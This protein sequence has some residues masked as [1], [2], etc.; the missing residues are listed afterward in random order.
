[1]RQPGG[2][3]EPGRYSPEGREPCTGAL[4]LP[5]VPLSGLRPRTEPLPAVSVLTHVRNTRTCLP[6]RSW[7]EFRAWLRRIATLLGQ[8]RRPILQ[9]PAWSTCNSGSS[10]LAMPKL[11]PWMCVTVIIAPGD[12][13]TLV[14]EWMPVDSRGAA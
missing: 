14:C 5:R 11:V 8:P 1:L 13:H 10:L 4:A 2:G 12:R 6:V 3:C 7:A 9:T